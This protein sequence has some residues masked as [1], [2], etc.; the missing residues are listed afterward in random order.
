[1]ERRTGVC[2][3]QMDEGLD[4]GPVWSRREL[5]IVPE[6]DTGT[7]F[8]KLGLLAADLVREDLPRL[9]RGELVATPQDPARATH[10]PPLGPDDA[11]LDFATST[12]EQLVWQIRGLAPRPGASCRLHGKR[13]Q[14]VRILA[15][16][17][18]AEAELGPDQTALE[19]GVVLTDAGRLFVGAR[20]GRLEVLTAQLEGKRAL[21]ARDLINGRSLASGDRLG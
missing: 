6:D 17:A 12:A 3:M 18:V 21:A 1:G 5:D 13:E 2:L 15:A 11:R 7:L 19:P 4:T 20:S 8:D 10:A 14:Q 16:R 9:L